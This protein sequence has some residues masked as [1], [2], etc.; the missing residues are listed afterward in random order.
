[1][2]EP[3][4]RN[5]IENQGFFA[6]DEIANFALKILLILKT[7][8]EKGTFH[9]RLTVNNIHLTSLNEVILTDYGLS[10]VFSESEAFGPSDGL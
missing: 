4:I 2:A 7:L 3:T 5:Y 8:H 6:E 1:M 10:N 9:G